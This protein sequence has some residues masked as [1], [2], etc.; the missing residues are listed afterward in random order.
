MTINFFKSIS[1]LFS[2]IA[3]TT[4]L[5]LG[6]MILLIFLLP[7]IAVGV[8]FP[9]TI[10]KELPFQ[11][12]RFASFLSQGIVSAL[13]IEVIASAITLI[14]LFLD[15]ADGGFI[16]FNTILSSLLLPLFLKEIRTNAT[17]KEMKDN[18]RDLWLQS[19]EE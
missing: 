4:T 10:D 6:S 11:S 5:S 18:Y 14:K 8:Y 7:F 9:R 1:F 2:I 19:L 3:I 15:G 13:F 17:L 12:V 16:V